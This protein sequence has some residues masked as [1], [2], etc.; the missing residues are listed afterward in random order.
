M[1]RLFIPIATAGVVAAGCGADNAGVSAPA[2]TM[3]PNGE[4][5]VVLALD[6]SFRSEK[7]EI[8]AGTEVVWENRGRNSHDV[9]P[10]DGANAWGITAEDFA[11]GAQYDRVFSVPGEYRYYCSIHGTA[12]VG[13]TG[14]VVVTG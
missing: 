7:I 5:V 9:V 3:P 12:D 8:T 6:N 4:S 13:M 11:P 14:T 1:R 10:V 2:D